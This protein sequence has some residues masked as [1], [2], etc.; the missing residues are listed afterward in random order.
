MTAHRWKMK[1]NC[2]KSSLEQDAR[3]DVFQELGRNQTSKQWKGSAQDFLLDGS[4]LDMA[5]VDH[6]LC[7]NFAP[8]MCTR[9]GTA[10]WFK[11]VPG[12]AKEEGVQRSDLSMCKIKEL[13]NDGVSAPT[14]RLSHRAQSVRSRVRSRRAEASTSMAPYHPYHR[15]VEKERRL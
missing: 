10:R 3:S 13:V 9:A 6:H 15:G 2:W 7:T 5:S 11:G 12:H 4:L 8:G 1:R 14:A